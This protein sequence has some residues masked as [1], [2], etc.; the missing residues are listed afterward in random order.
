MRET[1]KGCS[2]ITQINDGICV[3]KLCIKLKSPFFRA[4]VKIYMYITFFISLK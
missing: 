3:F 1:P 4:M 2:T